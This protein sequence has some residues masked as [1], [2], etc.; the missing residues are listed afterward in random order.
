MDESF[1][2]GAAGAGA[3]SAGAAARITCELM[4]RR[5]I[6]ATEMLRLCP[7]RKGAGRWKALQGATAHMQASSG[8]LRQR[9][10]ASD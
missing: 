7:E 8:S 4:A 2:C 1:S 5:P 6:A 3:A 10:T 9:Q